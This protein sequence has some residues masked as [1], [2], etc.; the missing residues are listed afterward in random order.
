MFLV[1]CLCYSCCVDLFHSEWIQ[2]KI[3]DDLGR[4]WGIIDPLFL[5]V[6]L[7][8]IRDV[9]TTIHLS[10]E[11]RGFSDDLSNFTQVCSDREV[12]I[13]FSLHQVQDHAPCLDDF[14]LHTRRDNKYLKKTYMNIG[15]TIT[16]LP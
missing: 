6:L 7:E 1:L 12:A 11:R 8:K 16:F 14:Q 3:E 10:V 4:C 15:L 13:Y 9:C 2:S 5:L